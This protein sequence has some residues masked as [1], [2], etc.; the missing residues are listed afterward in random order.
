MWQR[1]MGWG[2]GTGDGMPHLHASPVNRHTP[3]KTLPSASASM[4]MVMICEISDLQITDI[5][6]DGR[7]SALEENGGGSD[8]ING[9]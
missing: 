3:V 9:K 6:L 4:R 5:E 7:I 1:G 2:Q 8:T